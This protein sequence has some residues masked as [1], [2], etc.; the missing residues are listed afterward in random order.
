MNKIYAG[1]GSRETPK[2]VLALFYKIGKS[3]A[4]K[5]FILRSGHADGSD[6]AFENGCDSLNGQKEIW[7]PWKGFNNS[8]SKYVITNDSKAYGYAEE[9]IQGFKYIK[10]QG[11]KKCIARDVLQVLGE[12]LNT[13]VDFVVCWTEDGKL[14]GGTRHAI[15][16]AT[17]NNISVFNRGSYNDDESFVNDLKMF[18][19]ENYIRMENNL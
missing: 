5:N 19:E 18:I 1:I 4:R 10:S 3:L 9:N 6:I 12:D 17:K 2:E 15:N 8:T 13:P 16:I 7:L 14:K 11:A